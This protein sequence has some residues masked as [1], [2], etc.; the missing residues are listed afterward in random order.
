MKFG[1]WVEPERVALAWVDKAGLAR[2]PWL[3]TRDGDY[4]SPQNAQICLAG[5]AGRKW[6]LDQLVSLIE[7]VHPDYLK[8]DNNFWINCNRSGHGHG[9]A[10]GNL[11]HVQALYELFDTLRRRYPDL[12]IENVSGGGARI[13]F[14]MLAYTDVAW[15]D[16]RTSP[17]SLVRHNI[18]GLTFAFPPAYLLSFL[19]DADG[20]TIAGA[21]DLQL[22]T[23]SRMPG[24]F[25]ITYRTDMLDEA[26]AQLVAAEITQYKA[27]RNI[28]A[29]ANASLL[30]MQTPYD[31]SGWDVLQEIADGGQTALIFAFK[32]P[33]GNQ[34]LI[35][36]PRGL[37]PSATYDVISVDVGPIGAARGD[38]LMQDGIE[39]VHDSGS[40]AH[41]LVLTAR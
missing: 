16:D 31:E 11:A 21:G 30:T 35:V 23:R 26:T 15:M 33:L 19:I 2:E 25:G 1:I 5:A 40:R 27:Y 28:I 18:E 3:A 22:L 41:L 37:L 8:W 38:A 39:L 9:A 7:R 17:S 29:S 12:L 36:R 20:E 13:D 32:G 14:G 24:V 34:R 6:V 10:D 4:G